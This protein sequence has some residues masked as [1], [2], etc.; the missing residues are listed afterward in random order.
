MKLKPLTVAMLA[1]VGLSACGGGDS[2]TGSTL[3][4]SRS[5]SANALLACVD[6]NRNWQCDDGDVTAT[7]SSTGTLP[8]TPAEAEFTLIE[9]RDSLNARTLLLLSERGSATVTGRSTLRTLLQ[10]AGHTGEAAAALADSLDNAVLEQGFASALENA[11][12]ALAAL[13]QFALAAADQRTATPVVAPFTPAAAAAETLASWNSN[14]SAATTR[15]LS[16][17]GSL[18][19]NNSDTNRLFLFDAAAATPDSDELDLIPLD[20]TSLV[21]THSFLRRGVALLH[22]VLNVVVDTVSAATAF[23]GAPSTGS[24]VELNPGQG[25]ATAQ[26]INGGREAIV[27][28]NMLNGSYTESDCKSAGQGNEGLYRVSLEGGSSYRLLADTPACVHSGFNLVATDAAGRQLAAWDSTHPMLWLLDGVT[29]TKRAAIPLNIDVATPV[30]A[31][32]MSPGGRY[33]AVVRYGGVVLVDVASAKVISQISGD[34]G[35][36]TGAGFAAG[37]RKLLVAEGQQVHALSLSNDLQVLARE[38]TTIAG[39][40]ETLASL[41]ISADGESYIATTDSASYWQGVNGTA[42]ARVGL[43][44]GLDVQQTVLADNRIVVIARGSQDQQ[45]KLLRIALNMPSV[46]LSGSP[47]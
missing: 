27:Q 39:G 32:A 2:S 1:A 30:Q 15:Q 14:E 7:V 33:L 5:I 34:W 4:S 20:L 12:V 28:L 16:T 40:T 36:V 13:K 41:S 38:V 35:N 46:D 37:A 23:T 45:F 21:Q 22:D 25:I 18:V 9:R 29:M 26:V 10:S 24:A 8:L 17:S 44:G 31:L 42:L 3:A 6:V 19:L 11:P 47:Q 43:A